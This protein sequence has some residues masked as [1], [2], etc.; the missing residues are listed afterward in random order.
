MKLDRKVLRTI[1]LSVIEE[2]FV[3]MRLRGQGDRAAF[4]S[5]IFEESD[6]DIDEQELPLGYGTKQQR[7]KRRLAGI[8]GDESAFGESQ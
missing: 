2:Q 1:I 3:P 7:E 4:A 6:D 8:Q 5:G